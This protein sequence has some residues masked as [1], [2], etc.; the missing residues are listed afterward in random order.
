MNKLIRCGLL[1]LGLCV[2]ANA[3]TNLTEVIIQT[4]KDIR[5]L[6]QQLN[7][8]RNH[9]DKQRIPLTE[10]QRQLSNAVADKRRRLHDITTSQQAAQLQAQHIDARLNR[11]NDEYQLIHNSL[12]EYRKNLDSSMSAAALTP[13]LENL[14]QADILFSKNNLPKTTRYMLNIANTIITNGIGGHYASG[15]AL[16]EAGIEIKGKFLIFGPLAYFAAPG[17]AGIASSTPGS[18]LPACYPEHSLKQQTAIANLV[19]GNRS[20]VPVDVS[21]GQALR[22]NQNNKNISTELRKGGI[23]V[24]PLLLVGAIA[25]LIAAWKLFSLRNIYDNI[26]L[27]SIISDVKNKKLQNAYQQ[28]DKLPDLV[29]TLINEAITYHTAPREHLEEIMHE[30]IMGMV[31]RLEK[32]L[33]TLAVMA[34]VAPL[35]GLLGTVTGMMHTFQLVAVFGTGDANLLSGGISEALITTKLG[36]VIAI[37]ILL[38]HAFFARRVKTSIMNLENIALRFINATKER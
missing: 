16:D 26:E 24:I 18:L 31:P 14:K 33:G 30:H 13:Y 35:L 1:L 17:I 28:A 32:H 23:V 7:E 4:Q 11:V 22:I 6:T 2:S 37:P 5:Q 36:L 9:I 19:V 15:V 10:K 34:G 38:T 3:N 27:D 12:V 25:A 8:L 20:S 29:S 21:D